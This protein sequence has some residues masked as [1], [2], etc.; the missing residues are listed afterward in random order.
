MSYLFERYK[1]VFALLC[2]VTGILIGEHIGNR[3][4]AA[5]ILS[6][7]L[8]L[9]ALKLPR[10]SVL[11]FIPLGLI[12]YSPPLP[13]SS[14]S[15]LDTTGKLNVVGTLYRPPENRISG[16]RL[17]LDI[18][19]VLERGIT[20]ETSGKIAIYTKEQVE[21]LHF[22]ETILVLD[23]RLNSIESYKNPGSFDLKSYY[24]H[25]D[26]QHLGFIRGSED[27][28]S[29]GVQS[30]L[31][32]PR[33]LLDKLKAD[34]SGFLHDN[35][36]S[37]ESAILSAVTVGDKGGVPHSVREKFSAIGVA[38]LLAISGLHVGALAL[39]FYFLIK[40]V[41]KRSE[42][43]LLRIKV[44]PIAAL[45]TIL[46]VLIYTAITGFSA[47]ATRAFI[48]V[49]FYLV[50]IFLGR[51][52]EKLNTLAAAAFLLLVW[53]ASNLYSLSF[54]LTFLAVLG[55]LLIHRLYPFKLETLRDK[56]ITTVKTTCGAT[57]A[58][59]PIVI[60]QFGNLPLISIPSNLVITPIVD[61]LLLP[62]GLLSLALFTINE[63]IAWP[64]TYINYLITLSTVEIVNLFY[65]FPYSFLKVSPLSHVS[66][67]LYALFAACLLVIKF[68][69][70]LKYLAA[71]ILL[72]FVVSVAYSNLSIRHTDKLEIS[73]LDTPASHHAVLLKLP[74]NTSI[75]IEGG[76]AYADK[77][78]FIE[79]A[80]IEP[81]LRTKNV[82]TL[83]YLI[84]TTSNKGRM[85]SAAELAA[86]LNAKNIWTNGYK[87]TGNLWQELK[88]D[89]VRW[90]NLQYAN[91][92][93]HIPGIGFKILRPQ[94]PQ[95]TKD[96]RTPVPIAFK[97]DYGTSSII[98][99]EALNNQSI[100]TELLANHQKELATDYLYVPNAG[101]PGQLD[102]II[103]LFKPSTFI[104]NI[105]TD[106]P[107]DVPP[108]RDPDILDMDVYET[109]RTGSVTITFNPR[110]STIKTYVN[111]K[112]PIT[113]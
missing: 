3:W 34:Y 96:S 73:I 74:D 47:S 95:A 22:G 71:L 76:Y 79:R 104:T 39:L 93:F 31:D 23:L 106:D 90:K 48:M 54:Q 63:S 44:A 78:D 45:I 89:G 36:K 113:E 1:I 18:S 38:H 20:Q 37:P 87:L 99:G 102:R 13:S 41:L 9:L 100:Q 81:F 10:L 32:Y 112:E 49:T 8:G 70:K 25:M 26:I 83:D 35:F 55:I 101:S 62:L 110:G 67:L 84:L 6:P 33:Y 11:L 14:H 65:N 12:I 53:N 52:E 82:R 77:S 17:F 108:D 28:L 30:Y 57:L 68:H 107:K 27:I 75:L 80:V 19:G 85:N 24:E 43:L 69:L 16:S 88:T 56:I 58:T 97:I 40:W 42:Y 91:E 46:P 72:G 29:F 66:M 64:L 105:T 60:N 2:L 15:A 51:D 59:L 21:N 103:H 111:G 7:L 86:N 61:L 5:I 50:A 98:L 92:Q 94:N 109:S 4:L